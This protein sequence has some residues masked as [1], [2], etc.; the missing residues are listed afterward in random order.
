[1]LAFL[2]PFDG[3]EPRDFATYSAEKWGS[4]VHNL[5][6]MEV[7]QKLASLAAA[8]GAGLAAEGLTL[9]SETSTERPSL[10]NHRKVDAQWLYFL[11]GEKARKDLRAIIDR[12]KSLAESVEDPAHHHRHTIIAV[13]V[14]AD[15]V[16]VLCGN[17]RNA[18]LDRNNLRARW[19]DSHEADRIAATVA[20]VAGLPLLFRAGDAVLPVAELDRPRLASYCEGAAE[21]PDW[22]AFE[23]RFA[24]TDP[25][26]AL[27]GFVDVL[28]AACRQIAR[29]YP[30][31]AWDRSRD[32]LSVA[33]KVVEEKK[34]K[35]RTGAG[36][37]AENE[38]V[39]IVGGLF[40]GRRGVVAGF[41][42]A[43]K[44]KVRV[45]TLTLPVNPGALR[46]LAS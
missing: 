24:A 33:Q 8:I 3:F 28:V 36:G 30:V 9:E 19:R 22:L 10:W 39:E 37:F 17:H 21:V 13:R 46:S 14:D 31:L 7:K 40:A 1:M 26:V 20:E 29:L 6:R 27:P 44:V 45:G 35:R 34:I 2:K 42:Q 38:P 4:N 41:D 23:R 43:G 5:A 25:E 15:G 18:W 12:H 11:R 16:T 32:F